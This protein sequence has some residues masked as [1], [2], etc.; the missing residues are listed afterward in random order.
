MCKGGA[1][2]GRGRSRA[3]YCA[4]VEAL[5]CGCRWRGVFRQK[6]IDIG[7]FYDTMLGCGGIYA[8][9]GGFVTLTTYLNSG[10][11]VGADG[12]CFQFD[13]RHIPG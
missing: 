6:R 2:G 5:V 9:I 10:L 7:A 13:P 1:P 11:C 3:F 8:G 12:V 4:V